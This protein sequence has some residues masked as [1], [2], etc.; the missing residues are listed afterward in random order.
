MLTIEKTET[1]YIVTDKD[2]II[3]FSTLESALQY[4]RNNMK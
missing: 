3:G 2:G 1:G 4:I